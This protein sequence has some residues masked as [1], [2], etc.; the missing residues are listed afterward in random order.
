MNKLFNIKPG[1]IDGYH[2][3]VINTH[4]KIK[5]FEDKEFDGDAYKF[6]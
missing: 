2:N 3:E 6:Y 1:Y 4:V 5:K